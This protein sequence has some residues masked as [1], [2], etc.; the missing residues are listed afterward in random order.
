MLSALALDTSA[1]IAILNSEDDAELLH[2]QLLNASE[3]FLSAVSFV[4]T[5]IVLE[6]KFGPSGSRDLEDFLRDHDIK[7][8]PVDA[9]QSR[10]ALL[11]YWRF[12]RNLHSA[13]LNF[14]DCFSYALAKV[15]GIPLLF[16]GGD[17]SKTDVPILPA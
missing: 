1:I 2:A 16:K 7:I 6:N 5:A 14:G 15:Q 4:E 3:L 17:F 9:A 13:R 12:G 11:A 8:L 10:A